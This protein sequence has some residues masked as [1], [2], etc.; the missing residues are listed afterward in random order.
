MSSL[1]S[2]TT[3]MIT[4]TMASLLPESTGFSLASIFA[5]SL[6][7]PNSISSQT[8]TPPSLHSTI[9]QQRNN[10]AITEEIDQEDLI[11]SSILIEDNNVNTTTTTTTNNNSNSQTNVY[12]NQVFNSLIANANLTNSR[13]ATTTITNN[14]NDVSIIDTIE[15]RNTINEVLILDTDDEG[16]ENAANENVNNEE[17]EEEDDEFVLPAKMARL[18][19]ETCAK[20]N[21]NQSNGD[22]E[23]CFLIL[24]KTVS[25]TINVNRFLHV[26]IYYKHIKKNC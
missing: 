25:T 4:T 11:D 23:V 17:E 13:G 10:E 6:S 19:N 18:E 3:T 12:A 8:P 22:E 20:S 16:D 24:I 15:R 9:M 7:T 26:F 5:N 21:L 2:S 14:N 1:S